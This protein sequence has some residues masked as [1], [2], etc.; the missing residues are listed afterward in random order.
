MKD[1]GYGVSQKDLDRGYC[2]P[3]KAKTEEERFEDI[4][5][6][7]MEGPKDPGGFLGRDQYHG[8]REYDED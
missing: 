1:A 2:Q 8:G 3:L 7:I 4:M 6:D 5:E